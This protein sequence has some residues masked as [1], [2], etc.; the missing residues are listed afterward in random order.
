VQV[1][2]ALA[3]RVAGT[4]ASEEVPGTVMTAPTDADTLRDAPLALTATGFDMEI[5]VVA[6]AGAM[7][8]FTY[9]TMPDAIVLAFNPLSTHLTEPAMEAQVNDLPAAVAD[10]PAARDKTAIWLAG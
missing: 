10:G 5:E 8:T 6:A 2:A 1:A 9:A 4:H 3:L 7:V